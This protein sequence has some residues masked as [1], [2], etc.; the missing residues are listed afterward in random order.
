MAARKSGAASL[1][2]SKTQNASHVPSA[3][4]VAMASRSAAPLLRTALLTVRT[5]AP[6]RRAAPSVSSVQLLG[7]TKIPNRSEG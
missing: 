3:E 7:M 5:D 4:S 2:A 6:A 1:S